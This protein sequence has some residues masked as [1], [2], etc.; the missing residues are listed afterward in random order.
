MCDKFQIQLSNMSF[1]S[2]D[3]VSPHVELV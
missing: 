1:V 3:N 2:N